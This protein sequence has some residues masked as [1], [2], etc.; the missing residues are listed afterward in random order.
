MGFIK[1]IYR[2]TGTL[3]EATETLNSLGMGPCDS[4][5]PFFGSLCSVSNALL[6]KD[7]LEL[8]TFLHLSPAPAK[9]SIP[10]H[11][12]CPSH[13]NI[14]FREIAQSE[15]HLVYKPE[16]QSSDSRNYEKA[17][18]A[19]QPRVMAARGAMMGDPGVSRLAR[20]LK[21]QAQSKTPASVKWRVTSPI[22]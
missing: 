9:Y 12:P 20:L 18:Q 13:K 2:N 6:A 3:S 22:L 7:E 16:S 1:V 14:P 8:L 4:P 10:Q 11:V 17:T 15:K 19:R 21:L 5:P